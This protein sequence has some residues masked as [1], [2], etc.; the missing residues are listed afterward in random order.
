MKLLWVPVVLSPNGRHNKSWSVVFLRGEP[1]GFFRSCLGGTDF[2]ARTCEQLHTKA[3][4]G[5]SRFK[6]IDF[7]LDRKRAGNEFIYFLLSP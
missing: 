3:A 2:G 6:Y 4:V 5:S 7:F 1:L